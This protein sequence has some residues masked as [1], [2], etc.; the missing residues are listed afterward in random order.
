MIQVQHDVDALSVAL[1]RRTEELDKSMHEYEDR[2]D[3][4]HRRSDDKLR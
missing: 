4:E 3:L 2:L 1:D